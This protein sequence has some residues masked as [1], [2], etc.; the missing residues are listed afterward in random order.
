[1]II[2][3]VGFNHRHD[4]D[5]FIE[6][7]NGYGDFLLLILKTDAVFNLENKDIIVPKDSFFLYPQGMPQ[8]YRCVPKHEF[9]NDWVHFQFEGDEE[10]EFMK[11]NIP[12]AKGITT[13]HAEFLSW[14]IKAIADEFTSPSPYAYENMQHYMWLI[15]NR[16]SDVI[17]LPAEKAH[18]SEYELLM[19]IRH[20]IYAEPYV[21]RSITWAA[22]EVRMSPASFQYYYKK[23]F[24]IT[25][26]QDFINAKTEYAK[27]LLTSTNLNAHEIA[28]KC[29]YRNYE[30]FARQFRERCGITPLDYRRSKQ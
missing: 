9:A 1:M 17:N 30:H 22:H 11:R 15:F 3:N 10:A 6:R 5:F 25:F 4:G 7:P 28:E 19:T 20:K 18:G 8:Y 2:N 14:C 13:P 27:M 26:V 24:D 12:Y 21:P 16:V 29:G 23:T